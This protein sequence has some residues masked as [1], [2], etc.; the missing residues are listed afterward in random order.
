MYRFLLSTLFR[1]G[2][3]EH[4]QGPT[5]SD[6]SPKNYF[7]PL[8]EVVTFYSKT[9]TREM[10][11][12]SCVLWKYGGLLCTVAAEEK[13]VFLMNFIPNIDN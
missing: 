2:S 4:C 3:G 1:Y 7:L 12:L 5:G 13:V 6:L 8:D 10:A 11:S 9:S